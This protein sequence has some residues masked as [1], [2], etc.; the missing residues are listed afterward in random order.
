MW[1][2]IL[3]LLISANAIA[4]DYSVS[5][6][7][8]GLKN[9]SEFIGKN[10]SRY[11]FISNVYSFDNTK[12]IGIKIQV[13]D[14]K[15]NRIVGVL[16]N[17]KYKRYKL[18]YIDSKFINNRLVVFA[19]FWNQKRHK[20]YVF[21]GDYKVDNTISWHFIAEANKKK[22]PINRAPYIRQDGYFSAIPNDAYCN[23]AVSE[24]NNKIAVCISNNRKARSKIKRISIT[25]IDSLYK[26][27]YT[28]NDSIDRL[29][30][31]NTIDKVLV[32]NDGDVFLKI[33]NYTSKERYSGTYI[34]HKKITIIQVKNKEKTTT[35]YPISLP[36]KY[37]LNCVI[38]TSEYG[39]LLIGGNYSNIDFISMKGSFIC[40]LNDGRISIINTQEYSHDFI[41]RYPLAKN[42][43]SKN[44][45]EAAIFKAQ[46]IEKNNNN[47]YYIISQLITQKL[48]MYTSAYK[49]PYYKEFEFGVYDFSDII[50]H[51]FSKDLN[52]DKEFVFNIELC[53]LSLNYSFYSYMFNDST[54]TFVYNKPR[55]KIH[56]GYSNIK[57]NTII[58]RINTNGEIIF[59]KEIS[60][61][62]IVS[63]NRKGPLKFYNQIFI[64]NN[65]LK[66]SKVKL[67]NVR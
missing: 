36:N 13:W 45:N 22:K 61:T 3:L 59:T 39:E 34:Y 67:L 1:K 35:H 17:L 62:S 15:K 47:E 50:I 40:K 11:Y 55:N 60:G 29:D 30:I 63:P 38:K 54:F 65:E 25:V 26:N 41:N 37:V 23:I 32:N 53:A 6:Q 7:I 66:T 56:Y 2:I 43:R 57:G 46:F 9:N 21:A 58:K 5:N 44:T 4:Q 27:I 51:K 42:F 10:D 52:S 49:A 14:S 19:G 8:K 12:R 16:S 20:Y 64:L 33:N 24:S 28:I 48:N 31:F 18:D